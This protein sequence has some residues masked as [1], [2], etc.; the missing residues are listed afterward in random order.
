MQKRLESVLTSVLTIAAVAMAAA[1]VKREFFPN[2]ELTATSAATAKFHSNWTEARAVGVELGNSEAALQIVEF[3]DLEC[4]A[5]ALYHQRSI[6]PFLRAADSADFSFVVVHRP[7]GMHQFAVPAARAAECAGA[8]G[9]FGVFV[10]SALAQQ[11]SF[12][13]APW[14]AL[15][16]QV[17]VKDMEAYS[18]CVQ[19]E[20]EMPR[21]L[22]GV[23]LAT[24]MGINATPTILLNGWEL[25]VPPSMETLQLFVAGIKAGERIEDIVARL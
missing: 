8:Q 22:G 10:D 24:R 16:K 15:A 14:E 4:S 25:P 7:L 3:L 20:R 2:A 21:V 19:A 17:G 13:A 9:A 18:S 23:S 12:P 11:A 5:C 1:V 6:K